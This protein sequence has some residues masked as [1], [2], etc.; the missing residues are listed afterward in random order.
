MSPEQESAAALDL[1]RRVLV[2][3]PTGRDA[4][5]VCGVLEKANFPCLVSHSLEALCDEIERGAGVVMV[6]EEAVYGK[7]LQRLRDIFAA[8]P[9]WSDL[10]LLVFAQTTT[11]LELVGE[12]LDG[13]TNVTVLERPVR[14]AS[15]LSV[16]ETAL[17][18]RSRQYQSRDLLERLAELDRKKDEFLAMLGHELRNPLAAITAGLTLL[19]DAGA[20]HLARALPVMRRQTSNLRRI[21]DDLLD[22]SRVL[23]GK[24]EL[25]RELVDLN[26]VAARGHNAVEAAA[27][28][29][30]QTI[31]PRLADA[32]VLVDADPVRLDQV[33]TNLLNNAVKYTPRGG[34]IEVQ[35]V[36][37]GDRGVFRVTDTGVG[38]A[39][40]A[41]GSIFEPFTQIH[42]SID[43][44]DGG[45]GLGLPLVSRL[46]ELH[47]GE[48][49]AESDGRDQGSVFTVH[50]P[51]A[52][53]ISAYT[54]TGPVA[55]V[56]QAL[57]VSRLL[58]VEDNSDLR[59]LLCELLTR[60]GHEVQSCADGRTA[61]ERIL[62]D[63]PDIALVDIGMPGMDGYELARRVRS[64]D[65][66]NGIQL[67]AVTGYGQPTDRAQ[68]LEAGFDE[69]MVKPVEAADLA[70]IL[71]RMRAS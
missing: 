12:T 26:D 27:A 8:Q 34:R 63:P 67:V 56:H 65:E 28:S 45:L 47:G 66:T 39:A 20:E 43:R 55:A 70:R 71:A 69:H 49:R 5:L 57:E 25:H 42:A 44:S 31:T 61:L 50:L 13:F 52:A 9:S 35:V 16:V 14:I 37:D 7:R 23:T 33:V 38:I 64:S 62:C 60:W 29:R 2:Y 24:I 21:V 18:S 36:R 30:D 19:E 51:L 46:V 40:E 17:R 32:P 11:E 6:A 59:D 4:A 48:V 22:V 3:T 10:Q 15:M 1:E 53:D 68:A 41:L 54:G 58:V